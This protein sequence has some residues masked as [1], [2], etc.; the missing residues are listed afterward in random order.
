M[1]NKRNS[2]LLIANNY[3]EEKALNEALKTPFDTVMEIL[4]NVEKYLSKNNQKLA[5]DVKIA[6]SLIRSQKLYKYQ[7]LDENYSEIEQNPEVRN[8]IGYLKQYSTKNKFTYV[9]KSF[10]TW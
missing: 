9:K 4:H 6:I 7:A 2:V 10:K 3:I 1:A 5:N 8:I